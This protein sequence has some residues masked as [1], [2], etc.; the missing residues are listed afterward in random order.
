MRQTNAIMHSVVTSFERTSFI[1]LEY[2]HQM[3]LAASTKEDLE[4]T[5][6][7]I[8]KSVEADPD[9]TRTMLAFNH[10]AKCN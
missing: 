5:S 6:K 1:L 8:I 7:V 9:N 4:A 2:G 10:T 3:L